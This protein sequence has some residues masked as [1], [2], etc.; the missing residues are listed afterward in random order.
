MS[1]N[2]RG[3]AL[4]VA[5]WHPFT[6]RAIGWADDRALLGAHSR[7]HLAALTDLTR[8]SSWRCRVEYLTDRRVVHRHR[9][10]ITTWFWPRSLRTARSQSYR[11]ERSST[12]LT[13]T[14]LAPADVTI[15]NLSGHGSPFGW[16]LGRAAH[17]RGRRYVAMI[18]GLAV[19]LEG[20]QMRFLD[21]ADAVAVHT[22]LL[23]HRLAEAGVDPSR[24][25]VV[26]LGVD[27]TVFSCDPSEAGERRDPEILFVGRVMAW[28][29]LELLV[30]AMA[31]VRARHPMASLRIVG[32]HSD[33]DH[34][35]ALRRLAAKVGVADRLLMDGPVDHVELPATYRRASLCVL[36]S[37]H[38]GFGMV[39]PEALACGTPVVALDGP[40]GPA[41]II[42]DRVSG[43]L[44]E[45]A[46]MG[47]VIADLL[48]NPD[49]L[50]RM[51][52]S[53]RN[54]AEQRF[55]R[56]ATRRAL[57]TV[58]ERAMADP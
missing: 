20:P 7:P 37:T 57:A 52:A 48:D 54:A 16:A 58:V 25:V 47:T 38:E 12:G 56:S 5:L 40:G 4:S 44:V 50:A 35:A 33:L 18:G 30:R 22:A 21:H 23:G 3:R 17:V 26:P 27:T 55:D 34:A 43:R 2:R 53:A 49:E 1:G 14:A 31:E 9:G 8:S 11:R 10:P 6:A 32:P 36:P 42:E 46:A 45:G 39:V 28:K 41:E 29:G 24:I 51:S 15:I 19:T 13:R